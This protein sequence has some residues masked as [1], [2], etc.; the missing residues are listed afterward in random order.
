MPE[1]LCA[2]SEFRHAGTIDVDVQIDLEI[3]CGATN[4]ARLERALR[5]AEFEPD[6]ERCWRWAAD[7]TSIGTIVKFE[8]LADLDHVPIVRPTSRATRGSVPHQAFSKDTE[9]CESAL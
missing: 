9:R 5:N 4:A 3:A 1:L 8:L 2:G 7:D 6:S